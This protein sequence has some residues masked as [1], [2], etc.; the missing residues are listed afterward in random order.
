MEEKTM[1]LNIADQMSIEDTL[2]VLED[3]IVKMEDRNSTL[4]ESFSYYERGMKLVKAC[5][6][7][8]DKVEKQIQ[9]LSEE[10]QDGEF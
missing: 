5:S 10:G 3:I 4:E 6:E 7:K 1:N 2:K 8:I 9:I